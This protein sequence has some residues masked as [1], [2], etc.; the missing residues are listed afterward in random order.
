MLAWYDVVSRAQLQASQVRGEKYE[1]PEMKDY[2]TQD[3]RSVACMGY[4]MQW[5]VMAPDEYARFVQDVAKGYAN[6]NI[7]H[8][9]GWSLMQNIVHNGI[10]DDWDIGL[11]WDAAHGFVLA[12]WDFDQIRPQ[13]MFNFDTAPAWLHMRV[14]GPLDPRQV[15]TEEVTWNLWERTIQSVTTPTDSLTVS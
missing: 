6:T 8:P 12:P 13:Q 10:M 9:E 4:L 15:V 1:A 2:W 11:E 3:P 14:G 7:G 5:A